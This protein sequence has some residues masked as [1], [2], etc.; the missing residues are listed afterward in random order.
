MQAIETKYIPPTNNKG[1][2]IKAQCAAKTII[3]GYPYEFDGQK[4]HRYAM[5]E[6]CQVMGGKYGWNSS[7]FVTGQLKNGN[8]VHVN[9]K[10]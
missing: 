3:I 9:I 1:A 10:G 8:Y 5:N 6:L 4:A 7:D 2:R